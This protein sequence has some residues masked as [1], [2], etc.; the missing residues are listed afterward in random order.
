MFHI[1]FVLI[2]YFDWLLGPNKGNIFNNILKKSSSQKL[3]DSSLYVE[4]MLLKLAYKI[5]FLFQLD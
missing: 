4:Y 1:T 3:N 2:T 5:V